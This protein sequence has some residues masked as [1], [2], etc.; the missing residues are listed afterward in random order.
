MSKI[1]EQIRAISKVICANIDTQAVLGRGLTSQNIIAQL[2][3]FVE[4][5]ALK[6]FSNGADLENSY[7]NIQNALSYIKTKGQLKFLQRFHKLLQITASHYTLDE[8]NS[9]RL[10]LK[11]FEYL[12]RIRFHL[13]SKFKLET[14]ENLENFPLNQDPTL[15]EYYQKI[16]ERLKEEPATRVKSDYDDRYYL[17]K[18]KPF[19]VGSE[20]FY[21]VTFTRA[22]DRSNKFDRII[23]FTRLELLHNYAV[24]LSISKSHINIMGKMMPVQIIDNWE[25]S[26]RPCELNN[27]AD[28]IGD[29][30]KLGGNREYYELMNYIK[31]SGDS[32]S[33][34]ID[35][36]D[37]YF[38]SVKHL[39]TEKSQTQHF[40]KVLEKCRDIC[41][42]NLPG[43]NILKY[44]L[45]MV[46]NRII[47]KQRESQQCNNL[48]DLNLKYGCIPF[49]EMPFNSSL[50]NHNPK[51]SHLFECID[52]S[53]RQ[54]ELFAR[55]LKNNTEIKGILYTPIKEIKHF[56]FDNLDDLIS[57]YN[58]ALYYKH[59]DRRIENY[60]NHL[61]IKGYE[62]ATFEIVEKLIDQS[63]EG[64]KN[65]HS[66]VVSWL[67]TSSYTVDCEEKSA[68][69]TKLFENSKVALVYGAAG[70]GKS[71]MI[72][73]ISNFFKDESKLFLA[74]TNP[75]VDN[76]KRKVTAPDC[77]FKTISK[78]LSYYNSSTDYDLIIVDE[79]S[80]VS[81]SNMLEM[82]NKASYNLLVLVGDVYQIESIR[83][84]NWFS[85]VKSFIHKESVFE[86]KKPYRSDDKNLLTYWE[87]V[88]N[89]E[90]NILELSTK[91]QYS[92]ILDESIFE[93]YKDDE[94]ILCLN[95]DGLYGINNINRFLQASNPNSPIEWGIDTYK[96][97]DPILFNE[98]ER[99]NSLLF[100]NL[101]GKIIDISIINNQ[102]Q[103]DIEI[104]TVLNGFE[105]RFYDL[106]LLDN[107]EAGNSVIR[108]LVNKYPSTDDDDAASDTIVPFQVAYAV[109][110]HKAQGLE[111]NSVKIV[112]TN[113]VEEMISHNIFY[114]AITR[115]R[116]SLKIY[117]TP[118]SEN[119]ILNGLKTKFN[120]LDV[121][122][123]KS[124]NLAC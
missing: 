83:F 118:E 94:I 9:E 50:L 124:K 43:T 12:F 28:I 113:E 108:F 40:F 90:D 96:I 56:D 97:N 82:L 55:H 30:P 110:I 23:A 107:S 105:T 68:A 21:E 60:K 112:I 114:T 25:V 93:N 77:E 33:D 24:K 27:F 15:F 42:K 46:N 32:L 81:N 14:L 13:K 47:K 29:H 51:L 122:L 100:N 71:T 76:L 74:N 2:R 1:D 69:L 48:S 62:Q 104:D 72:N 91:K 16:S 92:V 70:T 22:I 121:S 103:F 53:D 120:K 37:E 106:D 99:F 45:Y 41:K 8:E 80:T 102:I 58:N 18:I 59:T 88:R 95:Y 117:W 20:I 78:F 85:I 54:H 115:A 116:N 111:Y 36:T 84:G 79:C 64:I 65:Y 52:S 10:M 7:Q 66:S 89:I 44:L 6:E 86:L 17:Q 123:L 98:N 67:E 5:I 3:N 63:S 39:I 35:S 49:D 87:R 11:Y 38:Y 73:H 109:S 31:K 34:L 101:K 119:N 61:Y 19:F 57:E 75:A 26:I 4:H